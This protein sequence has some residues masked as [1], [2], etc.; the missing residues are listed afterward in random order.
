MVLS[1]PPDPAAWV[2]LR[3]ISGF[4]EADLH[5]GYWKHRHDYDRGTH[6]AVTYWEQIAIDAGK[7]FTAE[8]VAALIAADVDLWSQP[9]PPMLT[10]AQSLQRSGIK[11]GILSNIGDAMTAGFLV[12]FPWLSNFNHCTW[13]Y[14][15]KM[16]KPETAIY[17]CA[18]EALATSPER[19]LFLD[20]REENIAAAAAF[21]MQTI[22]YAG[23]DA[24]SHARFL[25]EMHER[26]LDALLNPPPAKE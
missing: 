4:S 18:A 9:N 2:R 3:Q 24:A 17:R 19:I 23:P 11:T 21:G 14:A 13:S 25:T 7:H 8:Q 1:G 20:D 6:T 12:K 26:G 22:H 16:A 10:W 15:L 5:A